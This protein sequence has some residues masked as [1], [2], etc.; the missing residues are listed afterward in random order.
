MVIIAIYNLKH[1]QIEVSCYL[2]RFLRG[3]EDFAGI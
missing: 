1:Q 2:I 3:N